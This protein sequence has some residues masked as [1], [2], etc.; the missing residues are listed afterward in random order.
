M[1]VTPGNYRFGDFVRIGTPF[2][3][4]VMIVSVSWTCLRIEGAAGI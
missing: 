3:V 4:I 2:T 1:V